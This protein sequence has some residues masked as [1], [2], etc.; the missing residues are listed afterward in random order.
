MRGSDGDGDGDGDADP[1]RYRDPD[2]LRA[3]AGDVLDFYYPACVDEERGGFVAQLDEV[4]GEV[5]DPAPR[6]LVA[7]ARFAVNFSLA[8]ELGLREWTPAAAER[9]VEFLASAHRDPET[10]GYRWL[11]SGT[12]PVD[13]R[14][15]TYGHAFVLLAYA[16]ATAAGVPGAADLVAETFELL[17]ERFWEPAHEMF[18][19]ELTPEWEPREEG[20]RGQNAN[21]HACEALLAAYEATGESEY[22]DRSYAVARAFARDLA[23]ETD[24][25][26]W[27]H[28]DAGWT[29]DFG[30]NREAPRDQFRPWGYQPGHHAEWA[31]LLASLARHRD[32]PWLLER[33]E[34][35][36]EFAVGTGWDGEYG[37]FYYTLD[38]EGDPVVA[39]KYGWT[40]AEGIGA[41][42][43]LYDRTGDDRYL[44]WYDRQWTYAEAHLVS[45][46]GN[47]FQRLTRENERIEPDEG[48]AVEPGY[49]PVGAC[50]EGLRAFGD[51][52]DAP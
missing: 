39:D 25:L 12:D 37:G 8:A 32:E 36:F 13:D 48:P 1:H 44:D 4:T 35:L 42:A 28:Y 50:V 11:L 15:S 33:A 51:A 20:Y 27:E 10:G 6:H 40:V 14:R 5:Y 22:L 24:G 46:D 19:S 18:R 9:A 34:S 17:D 31:K 49:H 16:R 26:L 47:W 38:R 21:M 41:A 52:E 30:Y 3:S 45:E 43:A 23:A 7:S 2:R 29:H